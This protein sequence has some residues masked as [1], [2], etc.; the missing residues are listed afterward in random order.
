MQDILDLFD[1][2]KTTNRLIKGGDYLSI[3]SK[4]RRR[5]SKEFRGDLNCLQQGKLNL[6]LL[7]TSQHGSSLSLE[8]L[9]REVN[10][11]L[12]AVSIPLKKCLTTHSF[13]NRLTLKDGTRLLKDRHRPTS[14][15][16]AE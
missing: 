8:Y 5:L 2:G 6:D 12:K 16:P 10:K 15:S 4:D 14:S 7:I 1:H 13:Q 11:I 3:S 9:V